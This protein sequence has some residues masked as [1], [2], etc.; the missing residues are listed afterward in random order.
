MATMAAIRAVYT[1]A[2]PFPLFKAAFISPV[3]GINFCKLK[4]FSLYKKICG[5]FVGTKKAPGWGLFSYFYGWLINEFLLFYE[6]AAGAAV[7]SGA[8]AG[9]WVAASAEAGAA[10]S[11]AGAAAGGCASAGAA[12]GVLVSVVAALAAG[13]GAGAG[14]G[15]AGVFAATAAA[16]AVAFCC[17]VAT[18]PLIVAWSLLLFAACNSLASVFNKVITDWSNEVSLATAVWSAVTSNMIFF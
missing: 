7:A 4:L 11:A 14:A 15:A 13:A 1:I 5:N 10:V 16:R 17:M 9:A 6:L 3:K 12:A 18:I 8:E 2:F